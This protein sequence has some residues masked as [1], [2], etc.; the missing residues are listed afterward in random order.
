MSRCWQS[1]CYE[2]DLFTAPSPRLAKWQTVWPPSRRSS[3]QSLTPSAPQVS[4]CHFCNPPRNVSDFGAALEASLTGAVLEYSCAR[5]AQTF[6]C[7]LA[8]AFLQS[9]E[10]YDTLL[11][12]VHGFKM[13][14]SASSEVSALLQLPQRVVGEGAEFSGIMILVTAIAHVT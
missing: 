2:V 11:H 4:N 13:G 12:I 8:W 1:T 14:D 10:Q 3:G 9:R 5:L 7:C 6:L